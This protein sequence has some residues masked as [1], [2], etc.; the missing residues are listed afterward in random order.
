MWGVLARQI[1]PSCG[2]GGVGNRPLE[3][4]GKEL[5]GNRVNGRDHCPGRCQPGFGKVGEVVWWWWVVFI[6]RGEG[7]SGRVGG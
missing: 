6:A 5:R 1:V 4:A 3:G 2:A 7:E